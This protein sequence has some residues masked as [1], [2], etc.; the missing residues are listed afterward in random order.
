MIPKKLSFFSN[1]DF[2]FCLDI[3]LGEIIGEGLFWREFL[4]FDKTDENYGM[5]SKLSFF[6]SA[7]LD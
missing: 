3:I 1:Y 7:V 4:T 2:T 5:I 6:F